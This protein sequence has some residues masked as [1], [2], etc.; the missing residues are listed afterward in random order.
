MRTKVEDSDD[1]IYGRPRS[2]SPPHSR[3]VAVQPAR[4]AVGEGGTAYGLMQDDQDNQHGGYE[5]LGETSR[6]EADGEGHNSTSRSRD[7]GSHRSS[8]SPGKASRA[9]TDLS[10]SERKQGRGSRHR[11]EHPDASGRD[12]RRSRHF[13][14]RYEEGAAAASQ[15][16][17]PSRRHNASPSNRRERQDLDYDDEGLADM[18]MEAFEEEAV[19]EHGNP[20][21]LVLPA[22]PSHHGGR[23]KG[24]RQRSADTHEAG[25]E[26]G[27]GE[28]KERP[29]HR[30][31]SRNT[32]AA[33][34]RR[35]SK[36]QT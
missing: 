10:Q 5:G 25:G 1:D 2:P 33:E 23:K 21:L 18:E 20:A 31:S 4:P 6:D 11:D 36:R 27:Q 8:T 14:E 16:P 24:G 22:S 30:T 17:L 7:R 15:E 28:G 13:E 19:G 3:D 34:V 26:E 32:G 12:V 9:E 35:N 29:R